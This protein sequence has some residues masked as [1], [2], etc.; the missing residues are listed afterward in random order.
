METVGIAVDALK[1][2]SETKIQ[3][4]NMEITYAYNT[5]KKFQLMDEKELAK[6]LK[7]GKV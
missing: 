2:F 4:A 5:D 1:K 6:L 7:T 3:P